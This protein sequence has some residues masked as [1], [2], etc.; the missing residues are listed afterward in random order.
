MIG[1]FVLASILLTITIGTYERSKDSQMYRIIFLGC[2]AYW[3]FLVMSG[4]GVLLG[5]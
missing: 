1:L 4:I 5:Y 2:V 3:V